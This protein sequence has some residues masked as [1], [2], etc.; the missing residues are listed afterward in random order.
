MTAHDSRKFAGRGDS[1]R[2]SISL[3]SMVLISQKA[4]IV[5]KPLSK[6]LKTTAAA[7]V[8]FLDNETI[9]S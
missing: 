1:Y 2:N 4:E 9:R 3:F 6:D 8:K 5:R 7:L